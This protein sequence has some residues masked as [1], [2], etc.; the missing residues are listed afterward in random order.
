MAQKAS[1][2]NPPPDKDTFLGG[3]MQF[4]KVGASIPGASPAA[5]DVPPE[6]VISPAQ[7][8]ARA[9]RTAVIVAALLVLGALLFVFSN[10]SL[11][12]IQHTPGRGGVSPASHPTALPRNF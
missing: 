11:G 1:S 4:N 10:D 12:G 8:R 5:G 2:S 7:A 3:G 6:V 9:V